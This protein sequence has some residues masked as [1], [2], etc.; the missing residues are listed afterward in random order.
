V[1]LSTGAEG[2]TKPGLQ[3]LDVGCLLALRALLHFE[4]DLL[5]FLEGLETV[6]PYFGKVCEQVLT[7]VVRRDEAEAFSVVEPFYDTGC[8]FSSKFVH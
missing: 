6:R 8:H 4:A 7:A 2:P 1:R 3:R 5:V